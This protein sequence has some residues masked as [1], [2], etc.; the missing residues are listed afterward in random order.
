MSAP[1]LEWIYVSPCYFIEL[2][3]SSGDLELG[4]NSKKKKMDVQKA[5]EA[6]EKNNETKMSLVKE[7]S[8]PATSPEEEKNV[9]AK[10]EGR[11]RKPMNADGL[12]LLGHDPAVLYMDEE[13]QVLGW[14]SFQLFHA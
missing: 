2:K 13:L 12:Q 3:F 14:F 1:S 11:R 8:G 4:Q 10:K 7:K 6:Q 9:T 5:H